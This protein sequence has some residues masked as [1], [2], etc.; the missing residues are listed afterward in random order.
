MQ[1]KKCSVNL[2]KPEL[3]IGLHMLNTSTDEA[4]VHA[5]DSRSVPTEQEFSA[6]SVRLVP[7]V[8]AGGA[9]SRLWPMSREQYPKQLI[10]VLG[11]ES[12][13]QATVQRMKGFGAHGRLVGAPIVICGEE[14]R[15]VTAEQLRERGVEARIVVEPARRDTAPAL[16]LAT[17]TACA[18]GDDAIVL[19]MP[20]DHAIVD[21]AAFQ[22]AVAQ[23]A[24]HAERGAIV[25]LGVPP[26]RAETGFGYIKLGDEISGEAHRIERFV[27]KPAAEIAAQYVA[28]G[29]YWWNSGIFVLR[30]SVWLATLKRLQPATLR[31]S[32]RA[33]K[34]SS[35]ARPTRSTTR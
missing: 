16:T 15:F 26:T 33:L 25:A 10:D 17:T 14:H 18:D 19:V 29:Q 21:V 31:S 12:L 22:V 5:G 1:R 8:L 32:G 34:H 27:E 23:A 2:F 24:E 28:S 20:A 35:R 9:G 13:L 6:A 7:V 4:V 11:S 3:R 30:A